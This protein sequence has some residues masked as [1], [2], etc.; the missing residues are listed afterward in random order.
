MILEGK[1]V[2][3][4][5]GGRGIGAAIADLL[6]REGARIVVSARSTDE[7]EAV[8]ASLRAA[9]RQAWAIP[10][11]V[12]D[13]DQ[14]AELHRAALERLG[15]VDVLVNNAGVADSAPLKAIS[16]ESW[17]RMMAVNA[18]GTFL[19]TQAFVPGMVERGWGRVVNVA[20]V[21]GKVG[22]P[23]MAAYAAS[24][25]AALGFTRSVAAEV[26][27]AG[28]TVNAVCPG[29]VDTP[30]TDESVARIVTKTGSEAAKA[31]EHLQRTSPQ[32]RLMTPEEVAFLVLSLCDPRAG[33]VN[34]QGLVLDGGAVQS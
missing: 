33:G 11:D 4:T 8:A 12:S 31:R 21:A 18:T 26:A 27:T 15:Q 3:I 7:I 24:K 19:C 17:N 10:C 1:G 9:D 30:M 28:V 6:S 13:P 16:L 34:G 14:I 23:Y 32:N 29:F 5:G 2:V 25:H 20:S 22:G